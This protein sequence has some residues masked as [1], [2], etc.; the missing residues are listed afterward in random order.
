MGIFRE[1]ILPGESIELEWQIHND[2]GRL[3]QIEFNWTLE[4]LK[5]GQYLY[6]VHLLRQ[7]RAVLILP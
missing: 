3:D 4:E 5:H 2:A 7:S 6:L 1:H